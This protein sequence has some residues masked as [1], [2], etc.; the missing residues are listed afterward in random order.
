VGIVGRTGSGKSTTLLAL[1]RLTEIEGGYVNNNN[2]NNNN[3]INV[4]L[5]VVG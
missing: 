4:I 3:S 2:D 5:L 1:L